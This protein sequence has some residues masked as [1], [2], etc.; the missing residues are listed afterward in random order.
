MTTGQAADHERILTMKTFTVLV[1][2]AVLVVTAG[3]AVGQT[4]TATKKPAISSAG[5]KGA[6]IPQETLD[7]YEARM[8]EGMP[9]R[10]LA[11]ENY[12]ST[13]KYPLIL[14]LHG[15]GGV[16]NDNKSSMR[17]WTSV[18]VGEDWRRTY[19]CFVVAPQSM[20]SWSVKGE[21]TPDMT[22]D[23]VKALSEKWQ[24]FFERRKERASG[25]ETTGSLSQAFALVE[26]LATEYNI[27]KDRVYVLGHSMGGFGSWNAI[28]QN[29][30]MFAAAIP[31][32]GGLPPWNDRSKFVDVPV[33]AFH[34]SVDP[35]VPTEFTREIFA[36]MQ[37]LGGN[38]KYTELKDIKHNAST[39]AFVYEGDDEGKGFITKYSS[40]KCDKTSNIWDWLFKQKR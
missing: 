34:G 18:F 1:A 8:F 36:D 7:K 11:P 23:E 26:K 20:S 25:P 10:F 5:N 30:K 28:C 40:N 13:R 17:H 27:D 39:F 37:K 35:T 33:W 6:G 3:G 2:A 32:A 14:S 29:P 21:T 19:P 22:E 15:R 31:S 9:Y 24:A 12:D 38:M 4:R 16:G